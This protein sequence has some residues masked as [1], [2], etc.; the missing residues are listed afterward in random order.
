MLSTSFPIWITGLP[1]VLVTLIGLFVVSLLFC[2][3]R[4]GLCVTVS[5]DY[6]LIYTEM[7]NKRVSQLQYDRNVSIEL[8]FFFYSFSGK[9]TIDS[10]RLKAT[11]IERRKTL[12]Y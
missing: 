12:I 10:M 3:A 6:Y 9:F 11:F 5:N 1:A 7:P 2:V 8:L 4:G